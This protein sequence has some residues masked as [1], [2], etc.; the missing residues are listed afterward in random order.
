MIGLDVLR[1]LR[2]LSIVPEAEETSPV[3]EFPSTEMG[4]EMG[5][6]DRAVSEWFSSSKAYE[7]VDCRMSDIFRNQDRGLHTSDQRP[8]AHDP[9]IYSL[10]RLLVV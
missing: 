7:G 10:R 4:I 5:I 3:S 1:S 8:D 9:V 2:A 6:V